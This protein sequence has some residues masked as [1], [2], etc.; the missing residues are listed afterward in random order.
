MTL[1]GV[2]GSG[3]QKRSPA[4]AGLRIALLEE[5]RLQRESGAAIYQVGLPGKSRADEV[6]LVAAFDELDV[7]GQAPVLVELHLRADLAVEV[8]V[9][10]L[11]VFPAGHRIAFEHV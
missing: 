7:A 10:A 8:A 3:V 2:T 6:L 9:H 11:E 5:G 1:G 4:F